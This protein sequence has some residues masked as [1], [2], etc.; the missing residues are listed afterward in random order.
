MALFGLLERV[1]PGVVWRVDTDERLVALSFD[2]GPHPQYTPQVLKVLGDHHARATFFLIGER[3]AAHPELVAAI[4]AGQHEVGNHYLHRGTT[5]GDSPT[6]FLAKLAEAEQI[7]GLR[8]PMVFRPPGGLVWPSQIRAAQ[9]R[10]YACVLGTAY[11]HDPAQPPVA[12]IEWLVKKNMVPGSIVILHDG[13]ADPT[14][15]IQALPGI[16]AEGQRRGMRFIT[17]GELLEKP[18]GHRTRS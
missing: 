6:A 11:P 1:A 12:Y 8:R 10:G 7:I 2:D 15:S 3:A 5:L 9:A 14:R 4:K 13:I 18:R 17:V 16:L